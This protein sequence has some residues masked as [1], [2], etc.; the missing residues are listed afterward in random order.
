MAVSIHELGNIDGFDC[1]QEALIQLG[2]LSKGFLN[3]LLVV[4]CV[5]GQANNGTS[6]ELRSEL[7]PGMD[8]GIVR[9]LASFLNM[10]ISYP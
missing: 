5:D 8:R 6:L 9:R 1:G 4:S 3:Q 10:M 2:L 7:L